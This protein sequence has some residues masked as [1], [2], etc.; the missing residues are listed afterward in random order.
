[1]IKKFFMSLMQKLYPFACRDIQV[2]MLCIIDMH[3]VINSF[4]SVL[5]MI[6]MVINVFLSNINDKSIMKW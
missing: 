4:F 6:I 1:M 2:S 5:V 3:D